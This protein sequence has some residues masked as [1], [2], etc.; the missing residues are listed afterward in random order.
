[1][2]ALRPLLREAQI[3]YLRWALREL[4][5]LHPD[6]PAIVRKLAQLVAE[7]PPVPRR[8]R[9]RCDS[10]A[11]LCARDPACA[12]RHCPGLH[13]RDGGMQVAGPLSFPIE[14]ERST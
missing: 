9:S 12:D 6:V 5:P 14:H 2:K 11:G 10:L 7:R 1:M 8:A 4:S 3:A 13:Q